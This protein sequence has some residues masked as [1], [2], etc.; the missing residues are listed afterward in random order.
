MVAKG[1]AKV[2]CKGGIGVISTDLAQGEYLLSRLVQAVYHNGRDASAAKNTAQGLAKA[3]RILLDG[4]TLDV[5]AIEQ[6]GLF[7]NLLRWSGLLA[8]SPTR[9]SQHCDCERNKQM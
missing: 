3:H 2:A 6:Y 7:C 4:V 1:V 9:R 8:T 5:D